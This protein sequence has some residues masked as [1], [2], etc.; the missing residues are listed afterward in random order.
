MV[1]QTASRA[2]WITWW[3]KSA[4]RSGCHS[5]TVTGWAE[6]IWS[7]SLACDCATP[8]NLPGEIHVTV[9]L[10][11]VSVGTE[12]TIMQEGIPGALPPEA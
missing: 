11:K 10:K 12:L 8:M 7:S 5:G 6:N 4:A 3:R 1:P 2:A 9:G